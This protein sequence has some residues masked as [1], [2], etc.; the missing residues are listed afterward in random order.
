MNSE[1]RQTLAGGKPGLAALLDAIESQLL[2]SQAPHDAIGPVMTACDEIVSNILDHGAKDIGPCIEVKMQVSDGQIVV[3]IVDDGVA[4]DPTAA[5]RPDTS[6]PLEE[7]ALG[8]LGIHLIRELMDDVR[9][10][11]HEERNY[12]RFSR[13][14]VRAAPRASS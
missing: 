13:G 5:P 7:R 1:F 10:E 2:E 14:R 6:L 3:Q 8:G 11:R 4:F 9:Y 12:L